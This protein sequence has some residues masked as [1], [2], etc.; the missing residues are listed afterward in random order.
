[1]DET[2]FWTAPVLVAQSEEHLG[3]IEKAASS[4]LA[5]DTGT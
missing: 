1:M 4:S 3:D 5:R 2:P